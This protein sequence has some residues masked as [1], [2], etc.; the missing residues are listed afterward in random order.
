MTAQQRRGRLA[1]G[2]AP[3]LLLG[4]VIWDCFWV[5][6]GWP[7]LTCW[8]A[9]PHRRL[10]RGGHDWIC[11]AQWILCADH[12]QSCRRRR[13]RRHATPEQTAMAGHLGH[14]PRRCCLD[15]L[16]WWTVPH[17]RRDWTSGPTM[18]VSPKR[19]GRAQCNGPA[20]SA[21]TAGPK[22]CRNATFPSE[23]HATWTIVAKTRPI[24]STPPAWAGLFGRLIGGK[25]LAGRCRAGGRTESPG[26]G[27][28]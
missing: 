16:R 17:G 11:I 23:S 24:P 4:A 2:A 20:G 18:P 13:R 3:A 22:S 15:S 27:Q 7:A 9:C 1:T 8:V 21:Q 10:R 19:S 25:G 26:R 28:P 6:S 12:T 5:A 14:S